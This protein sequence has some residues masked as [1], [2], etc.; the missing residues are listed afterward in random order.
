MSFCLRRKGPRFVEPALLHQQVVES[1]E[2]DPLAAP[3]ANLAMEDEHLLVVRLGLLDPAKLVLERAEHAK[4]LAPPGGVAASC[5]IASA[6]V[7]L[8]RAASN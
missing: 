8:G 3:T 7:S 2:R 4:G 5:A 1:D 6:A